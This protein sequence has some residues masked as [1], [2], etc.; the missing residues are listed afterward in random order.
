MTFI[1]LQS[2][3]RFCALFFYIYVVVCKREGYS[4][5][6]FGFS[7]Y[8]T[9]SS[10]TYTWRTSAISVSQISGFMIQVFICCTAQVL[11]LIK[12]KMQNPVHKEKH[13]DG[14]RVILFCNY[15]IIPPYEKMM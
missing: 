4:V 6:N 3:L 2:A 8:F 5:C 7:S 1:H 11:Y 13:Y 9:F 10:K 12:G 14:K 15:K